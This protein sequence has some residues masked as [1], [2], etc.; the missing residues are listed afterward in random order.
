MSS[1]SQFLVTLHVQPL[2]PKNAA[3]IDCGVWDQKEGGEPAAPSIK[4]RPGGSKTEVSYPSLVKYTNI[5]LERVYDNE[6]R[7]DQSL[8]A[9]LNTLCGEATATVTEQPLDANLSAFGTPRTFRGKLLTAKPGPVNSNSDDVRMW[10]V[11][12]GVDTSAH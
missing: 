6:T 5:T 1:Q 9:T 7:N 3:A 8:C 4:H 10:T 11:E 12:L 2:S